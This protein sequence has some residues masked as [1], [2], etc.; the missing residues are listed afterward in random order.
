VPRAHCYSLEVRVVLLGYGNVGKAFP[1]LLKKKR[2]VYPFPIVGIHT[3][4]HGSVFD[5][6]GLD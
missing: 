1:Q 5:F 2:S 6:R 3:A 4:N